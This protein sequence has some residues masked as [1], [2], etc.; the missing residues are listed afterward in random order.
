M[1]AIRFGWLIIPAP[2]AVSLTG[3]SALHRA[4]RFWQKTT[5]LCGADLVKSNAGTLVRVLIVA[6]ERTVFRLRCDYI[7]ILS[8]RAPKSIFPCKLW[9]KGGKLATGEE[10]VREVAQF[11]SSNIGWEMVI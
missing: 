9:Q 8:V 1:P 6:A 4:H 3:C 5:V 11:V 7:K 10:F 2:D